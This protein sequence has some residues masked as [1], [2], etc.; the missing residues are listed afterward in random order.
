LALFQS[1]IDAL[2]VI[3]LYVLVQQ[4]ENIVVVP[5]VMKKA[6]GLNPIIVILVILIGAKLGGAVGA[7]AAIPVTAVII[8]FINE[9]LKLK[10]QI[11]I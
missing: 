7:V 3:I 6:T 9:Y 4:I 11:K 10:E 2:M 1:P 5:Q 8:I